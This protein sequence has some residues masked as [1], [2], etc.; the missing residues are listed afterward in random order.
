MDLSDIEY[1]RRQCRVLEVMK[2]PKSS[3]QKIIIKQNQNI[4]AA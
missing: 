4:A 3:S 2:R 1:I